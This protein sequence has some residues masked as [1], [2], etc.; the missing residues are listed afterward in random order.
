[1]EGTGSTI[2]RHTMF[3]G[4]CN[5]F[6]NRLLNEANPSRTEY[7]FKH[8]FPEFIALYYK[9]MLVSYQYATMTVLLILH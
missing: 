6:A 5:A 8:H 9:Q 1:M 3:R 2:I 7:K 4:S